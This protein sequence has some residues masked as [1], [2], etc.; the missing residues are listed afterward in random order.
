MLS[1]LIVTSLTVGSPVQPARPQLPIRTLSAPWQPHT[2]FFPSYLL[3]AT[4]KT[5]CFWA[6]A[7]E[8]LK[9]KSFPAGDQAGQGR[10][11]THLPLP[12]FPGRQGIVSPT[13]TMT[14]EGR[15]GMCWAVELRPDCPER[16]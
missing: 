7:S 12:A 14:G 2:L 1:T 4:L 15:V 8:D 10:Q 13:E 11:A 3:S 9:H 5:H 6:L 16:R